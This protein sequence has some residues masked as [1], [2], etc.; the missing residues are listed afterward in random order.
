MDSD[1]LREALIDMIKTLIASFQINTQIS[2]L[3]KMAIRFIDIIIRTGKIDAPT[4]K[5]WLFILKD[6]MP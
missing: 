6:Y 2:N 5:L 1:L 3:Y 4:M